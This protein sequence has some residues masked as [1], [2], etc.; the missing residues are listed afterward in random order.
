MSE[1]SGMAGEGGASPGWLLGERFTAQILAVYA[2][3]FGTASPLSSEIRSGGSIDSLA[4]LP[5]EDL[6]RLARRAVREIALHEA[7]LADR[8]PLRGCDWRVILYS[9]AGSRSLREAIA[10]CCDCFEAIDWRCGR[11]AQRNRGD[12]LELEVSA[13]RPEVSTPAACLVD[14][15]GVT[16]IHALLSWLIGRRIPVR[17]IWLN[18]D[19]AVFAGLALPEMPFSLRLA[20]GWTG[21]EFDIAFLD[22]PV[23]R[24]LSELIERPANNVLLE[25]G[26]RSADGSGS[27]G[28]VRR[29]AFQALRE[30]HRLPRFERIATLLGTSSATLR[31]RLMREGS[32]YRQIKVSCR[33]ELALDLLRRTDMTIEEISRRLDYCD[34]DAFRQ[35]FREWTGL[36][37]SQYRHAS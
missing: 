37:P 2:R 32:S 22:Y 16:E 34:S 17:D 7:V 35:A 18:H 25:S 28:Q 10:R 21:F 1:I 11:M 19:P 24:S 12:A 14:L 4:G 31:R 29:A 36:S 30:T 5:V 26:Q 9:L 6:A 27:E 3:M 8:R 20:G 23:I 13:L 15:F 33:R